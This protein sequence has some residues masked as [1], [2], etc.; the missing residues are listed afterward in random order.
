MFHNTLVD[1]YA[2][3]AR[4]FGFSAAEIQGLVANALDAAWQPEDR[5]AA[6][7]RRFAAEPAW[8]APPA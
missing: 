7:K 3:L 5:R 6:L 8:S 1:E 4:V 2:T